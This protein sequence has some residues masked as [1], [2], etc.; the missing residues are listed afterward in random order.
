MCKVIA[1]PT[2]SW[3]AWTHAAA[4]SSPALRRGEGRIRLVGEVD[5]ELR[6]LEVLPEGVDEAAQLLQLPRAREPGLK[7]IKNPDEVEV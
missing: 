5:F 2:A 6:G 4:R 3:T 1:P 7:K